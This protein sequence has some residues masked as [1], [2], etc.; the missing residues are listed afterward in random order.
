MA[1]QEDKHPGGRPLAFETVE[2]LQ[3]AIR[4]YFGEQSPHVATHKKRVLKDDGTYFWV[5]EEYMTE[6]KPLTMAGLARALGITRQTLLNYET[7]DEFLARYNKRRRVVKST[8]RPSSL[9]AMPM[10]P[11]SISPTTTTTGATSRLSTASRS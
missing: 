7:K 9:L 6:Q 11:S 4:A 8:P 1:E 5:D 2:E 10:G 3:D